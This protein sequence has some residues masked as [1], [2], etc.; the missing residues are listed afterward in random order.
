MAVNTLA[1]G[2]SQVFATQFL[3][4]LTQ[5]M[6]YD[7]SFSISSL[8]MLTLTLPTLFMIREPKNLRK[9]AT[10][11]QHLEHQTSINRDSAAS[12]SIV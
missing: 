1:I 4:P 12:E 2:L 3:V 8:M 11:R 9:P 10:G 7:Q 5:R 6:T